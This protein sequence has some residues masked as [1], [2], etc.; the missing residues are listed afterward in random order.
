MAN[1][2]E[3]K[4]HTYKGDVSKECYIGFRYYSDD[5]PDG[6]E[7]Q[8]RLGL[9]YKKQKSERLAV[10][11]SLCIVI[12]QSLND[13][14]NPCVQPLKKYPKRKSESN[15][16]T[17]INYKTFTEAVDFALAKGLW[18]TKT[19]FDYKGTAK[20]FEKAAADLGTHIHI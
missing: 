17:G 8:V 15:N 14:W 9:N 11:K 10:G 4:L 18:A 1:H 7:F 12:E 20:F 13:G 2:S 16:A 6:K 5:L 3:V 19:T